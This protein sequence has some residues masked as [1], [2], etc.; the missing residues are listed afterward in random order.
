DAHD[1]HAPF[2]VPRER[3]ELLRG[4]L[5][6]AARCRELREHGEFA[7]DDLGLE[8]LFAHVRDRHA[9]W[10]IVGSRGRRG[11]RSRQTA[12]A[13]RA[14]NATGSLASRKPSAMRYAEPIVSD[15]ITAGR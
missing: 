7:A 2:D 15:S 12:P 3:L 9:A 6:G 5:R 4:G 14:R 13:S 10:S 8:V 11:D 1:A